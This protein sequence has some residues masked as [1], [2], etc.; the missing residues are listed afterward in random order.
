MLMHLI[1]SSCLFYLGRNLVKTHISFF[2]SLCLD[3]KRE[4]SR[5]KIVKILYNILIVAFNIAVI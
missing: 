3:I 1:R 4:R 5:L 2:I